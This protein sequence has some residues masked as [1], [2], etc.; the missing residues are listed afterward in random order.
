LLGRGCPTSDGMSFNSAFRSDETVRAIARW[1][2][3]SL[4]V[5]SKLPRFTSWSNCHGYRIC[6]VLNSPTPAPNR[7]E[8]AGLWAVPIR[9]RRA[10]PQQS[11]TRESGSARQAS[12][13]S[14][15]GDSRLHSRRLRRPE[16]RPRT[17]SNCPDAQAFWTPGI[18]FGV[19]NKLRPFG[20]FLDLYLEAKRSILGASTLVVV[21]Y[22]WRD[23]HVNE[24]IKAF[25][26]SRGPECLLRV[27]ALDRTCEPI[28][29]AAVDSV[30]RLLP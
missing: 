11:R 28:L 16:R 30:D 8:Q 6:R 26:Q 3:N 29:G 23:E 9:L 12:R 13:L 2:S 25:I 15:L 1:A 7:A 24:L 19:G 5:S 4:T 17:S 14:E 18:I 10:V 21:G 22:S 20:P 27:G